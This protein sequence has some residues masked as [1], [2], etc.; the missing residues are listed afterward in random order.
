MVLVFIV[1]I[2]ILKLVVI[3]IITIATG[4]LRHILSSAGVVQIHGQPIDTN[5]ERHH[6]VALHLEEALLVH[7]FHMATNVHLL[8]GTI[9]TVRALELRLLAALPLLMVAQ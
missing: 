9:Y 1:I 3:I 2:I 4:C 5:V 6:L 7:A 8:L